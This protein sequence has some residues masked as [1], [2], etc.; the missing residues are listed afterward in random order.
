MMAAYNWIRGYS[1]RIG[2]SQIAEFRQWINSGG[3]S[4]FDTP[5]N[6][7]LVGSLAIEAQGPWISA[8]I[9]KV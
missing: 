2:K 6:P 3:I 1:E 8:F 9:R 5:Q 7:F 4:L